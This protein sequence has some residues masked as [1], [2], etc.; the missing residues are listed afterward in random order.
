MVEVEAV[1]Q[2]SEQ[3]F[4]RPA[5]QVNQNC[6]FRREIEV[7]GNNSAYIAVIFSVK[8]AKDHKDLYREISAL[9]PT[10]EGIHSQW[11]AV[12]LYHLDL[13]P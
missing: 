7:I 11:P 4:N 2:L 13:V 12:V 5:L 8:V 6:L 3:A 10:L 9:E 1:L